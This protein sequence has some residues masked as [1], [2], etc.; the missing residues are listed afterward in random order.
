[1][2]RNNVWNTGRALLSITCWNINYICTECYSHS[3][4]SSFFRQVR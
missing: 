1:L 3:T 2:W 4:F